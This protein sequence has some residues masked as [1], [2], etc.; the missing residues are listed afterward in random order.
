[1]PRSRPATDPVS[2]HRATG[3]FYVT[4]GGKRRYLGADREEAIKAYHR[5]ALDRPAEKPP[6]RHANLSAKQLANRFLAAQSANWQDR[7]NTLRGYRGWLRRFLLDHP[8]LIVDELTV[9]RFAAWKISL[10]DRGY[11]A[12]SI[13]HFLGAVRAMCRFAEDAGLIERSPRLTRVKNAPRVVGKAKQLYT[14]EQIKKLLDAADGHMRA[15]ILL[16]L[17]CGFG[18]KDLGDLRWSHFGRGC[19]TLARSKTGVEQSFNLWPE[20]AR[21]VEAV[22]KERRALVERLARR[23]RE[24]TDAG[25]FLVT[26][27]W[28]A[29]DKN[30][31]AGEFR[32]LCKKA[33]VPCY[34]FYRLRH[35]ASTADLPPG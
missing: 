21:A 5:L 15:M 29:W 14:Q 11:S 19:V 33:G 25:N 10:S 2:F 20:T 23:G 24:R 27:Y 30:A 9:E 1:M 28:K 7:S 12:E 34:G 31:I 35:C 4:R 22:R 18:P 17:N 26:K 16:G 13:S 6:E 8:R 3:Q 32:K